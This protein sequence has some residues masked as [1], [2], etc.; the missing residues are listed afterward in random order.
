MCC[1]SGSQTPK[2]PVGV[3]SGPSGTTGSGSVSGA[4]ASCPSSVPERPWDVKCILDILCCGDAEDRA[5]VGK[6]PRLT[7]VKRQPK[8]VHYKKYAGGTW[9]DDG[10]TSGGSALGTKVWVNSDTHCNDAAATFVHEVTHTDQPESMADSQREYDAYYKTELWRIKKGLPPH[11]STFRKTIIDPNDPSKTVEVP[12]KNAIKAY[13][14]Q[15]YAYNPPTPAG[16]GAPPPK[17]LGLTPD[18][19]QVRLS[20]GTTR[21]PKEGDAYR[22]PDTGGATLETIDPS[23]WKCP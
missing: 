11:D 7:V 23:V 14:D 1:H 9:V 17:V 19:T 8:E 3:S 2:S 6:L 4:S 20:D 13:A 16:G 21:P 5:V 18:G 22:L 12:D 15:S 10:F